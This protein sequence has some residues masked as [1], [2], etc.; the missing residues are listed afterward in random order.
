MRY[1]VVKLK[2]EFENDA[3][4][5]FPFNEI[6][7]KNRALNGTLGL[8]YNPS[9]KLKLNALFSTGFRSPNIDDVGKV[10]DSQPG[11]VVVPNEDLKPEYTYN[12]EI[13]LTKLFSEKVQVN[14]VVFYTILI[15]AMSRRDFLYDGQ[16]SVLYDGVLSNVQSEV[17]VG[18]AFI[19][20][21]SLNLKADISNHFSFISSVTYSDGEDKENKVPLRHTTPVF[22]RTS[23]SYSAK[24]VKSEF[25][26]NFSGKRSF[27]N[28]PPEEQAKAFLYTSAG[29]LPW[30]IGN[31]KV[32]YQLTNH[33]QVNCA[34]ENIF[35]RH[36]RP[37]SS[38]ISAPGR[39]LIFAI[40][41]VF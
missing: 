24:K 39:N 19:Y 26:V 36:Y 17:N 4:Y 13:G 3:F 31:F 18:E 23:L 5:D 40:K 8:V 32:S 33:L 35:D 28:L 29:S 27:G 21:F 7:I 9:S 38:G 25:F 41:A 37:Y 20:G 12:F 10:F 15:D 22:G 30:A 6:S 2:S 1:S 11:T 14:A 16:D 34:L